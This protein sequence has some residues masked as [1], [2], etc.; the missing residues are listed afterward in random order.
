MSSCNIIAKK[1]KDADT[2][3]FQHHARS[4]YIPGSGIDRVQL[5]NATSTK[6]CASRSSWCRARCSGRYVQ[7]ESPYIDSQN[8][9]MEQPVVCAS[10]TCSSLLMKLTFGTTWPTLSTG[11]TLRS[12]LVSKPLL[13]SHAI[14]LIVCAHSHYM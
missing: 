11:V 4:C 10:T 7:S 6:I 13:I 9:H 5:A 2:T 8:A 12:T 3:A 14:S 1:K